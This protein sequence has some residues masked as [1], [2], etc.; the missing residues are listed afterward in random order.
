M[1]LPL[2]LLIR[3]IAALLIRTSSRLLR[4]ISA[5]F[6]TL[7][8]LNSH[9]LTQAQVVMQIPGLSGRVLDIQGKNK[10]VWVATTDGL[11]LVNGDAVEKLQSWNQEIVALEEAAGQVWIR[12]NYDVARIV[13]KAVEPIGGV[14]GIVKVIQGAAG[15]VLIGTSNGLFYV[16]GN[17]ARQIP[18]IQ[19]FVT[20]REIGGQAWIGT[21]DDGLYRL[22]GNTVIPV[23][24]VKKFVGMQVRCQSCPTNQGPAIAEEPVIAEIT[25]RLW[26]GG[27]GYANAYI[28]EG[29]EA[30]SISGLEGYTQVIQEGNNHVWI[31]TDRGLY[32]V[33]EDTTA[34]RPVFDY[35]A[36]GVRGV[37]LIKETDK[38][39]WVGTWD[40]VFRADKTKYRFQP[41]LEAPGVALSI[42]EIDGQIW[43][44]T[45]K[46]V[47]KIDEDKNIVQPIAGARHGTSLK[48]TAGHV[49]I[50][51]AP[52]Y[53]V[54][55]RTAVA[56]P[57]SGVIA[58]TITEAAGGMWIGTS[59]GAFRLDEDVSIQVTLQS[60]ESWW[61]T[62]LD[63]LTPQGWL[64][65]G[66]ISVRPQYQRV[67]DK[68]DPYGD[69]F[70]KEFFVIVTPDKDVFDEAIKKDAYAPAKGF[71]RSLSW[72]RQNVYISVRDKFGNT[73]TPE[74]ITVRILPSTITLSFLVALLWLALLL[75]LLVLAPYSKFCH[76]LL[77]SPWVKYGSLGLMRPAVATFPFIRRHIL[78]RYLR[79]IRNDKDFA[80]WRTRFV[81]P[82]AEL[83]PST[84]GM[85]LKDARK[86]LLKGQSGIGK[87]SY[88]KHLTARYASQVKDGLV[89]RNVV[90]VFIS[91]A[92]YKGGEPERLVYDQLSSYGRMNDDAL[93]E[94]I[95]K[96][97]GFLIFLDGLNEVAEE[98]ARRELSNFVNR[99]WKANYFCLSSQQTYPEF[100]GLP[101]ISLQPLN[102]EKVDELLELR[103]GEEKAKEVITR[104]NDET[105]KLYG[106]PRDLE[107]AVEIILRESVTSVPQTRAAL[108]KATLS[109]VIDSWSRNGHPDYAHLLHKRAYEMLLQRDPFFDSANNPL[110]D[111]IRNDLYEQKYLV[112]RANHYYYRHD[113]IRA[114]LAAQYFAPQWSTLLAGGDVPIDVNWLEMLKFAIP[115]IKSSEEVKGLLETVLTNSND[116]KLAG[117]LFKWLEAHHPSL[118]QPWGNDFKK[119][120]A[121]AI[122]ME[123]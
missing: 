18:G 28:I 1:S 59:S 50:A 69:S 114:Y 21:I 117:V 14:R 8:I 19:G 24:G 29:D 115:E 113:L 31:A 81:Y 22:A 65:E 86:L 16:E 116:K 90:P 23:G 76:D 83:L 35:Q 57:V 72:G 70:N 63:W 48:E 123:I 85:R 77:T 89:P 64:V 96:Q 97:G 106:I 6:T 74:P 75:L 60:S 32:V 26:F 11:Y 109:P 71:E 4:V 40:G 112:K 82:T 80:D 108:Y 87:T 13:G 62:A 95:L 68:T 5:L 88:F 9:A 105:Y 73:F 100:S 103:L 39:V 37:R 25:G 10:Q 7:V 79:E 94:W 33:G 92:S 102:K 43:I 44:G 46:G 2:R 101:E 49:W 107:F 47:Y 34:A 67:G 122:L 93:N 91:L 84:F 41:V 61:K 52:L 51:S 45:D 66:T 30:K 36:S 119:K 56:Q 54:D 3:G 42:E 38:Q 58:P 118:S 110:P 27:S 98:G 15:R 12:T 78:R 104:F 20:I 99:N 17:E 111:E 121:D 55:K 53:R 120:F